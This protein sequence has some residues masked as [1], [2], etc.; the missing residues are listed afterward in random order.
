MDAVRIRGMRF[1]GKHG[2]TDQERADAQPVHLDIE[3]SCDA[4]KA[5]QSDDLADAI[6]YNRIFR[7]CENIVT[8]RSFHLLEALAD[9]CLR[10]VLE[11][12]RIARATVRVSKP[13]LLN[14]STPEVELSRTNG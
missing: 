4:T 12:P 14:G 6:D 7:T 10:A 5:A 8:Q 9:A 2:V 13:Q 11:D 3:L 1:W